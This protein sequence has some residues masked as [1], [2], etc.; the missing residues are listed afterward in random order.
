MGTSEPSLIRL[1]TNDNSILRLLR[2]LGLEPMFDR[3]T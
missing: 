3:V 1:P 2:A